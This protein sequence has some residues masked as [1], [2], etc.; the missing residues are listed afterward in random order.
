MNTAADHKEGLKDNSKAK[1]KRYNAAGI[2]ALTD[3]EFQYRL[4]LEQL[5]SLAARK[6]RHQRERSEVITS[7]KVGGGNI[8]STADVLNVR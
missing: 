4:A 3:E 7:V 6:I 8:I 1:N 2:S 5:N